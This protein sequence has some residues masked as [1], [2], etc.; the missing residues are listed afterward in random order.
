MRGD[1][2]CVILF[3][4]NGAG[5][6]HES[7]GMMLVGRHSAEETIYRAAAALERSGE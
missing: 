5:I 7:I 2:T 3:E 1:A 6:A 4:M